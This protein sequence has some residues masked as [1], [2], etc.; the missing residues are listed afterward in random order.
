MNTYWFKPREFGYGATPV[1]WEGWTVTVVTMIVVVMTSMLAPVLAGGPAGGL[2]AIVIVVL[3]ITA[4][5]IVCRMKT[6]GEW[7]WRGR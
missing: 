1:T 2:T 7:R 3:A 5:I 4:F 6:D